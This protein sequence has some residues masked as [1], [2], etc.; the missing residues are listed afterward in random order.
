V[1]TRDGDVVAIRSGDVIYTPGDEWHWHG[2]TP[3]H[4]MSHLSITE[5]VDQSQGPESQWGAHVTDAEYRGEG[6]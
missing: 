4:F 3:G 5:G 2:A 6:E 1:Q